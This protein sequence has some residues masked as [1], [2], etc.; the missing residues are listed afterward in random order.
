MK[1]FF[2]KNDERRA[3]FLSRVFGIFSEEIV[4][5]WI[6]D[7]RAP[8]RCGGGRPKLQHG[9]KKR[10]IDFTLQE[11]STNRIFVAEM[12]CE[13]AY[14]NFKF[15]TLTNPQQLDH[16][17][18]DA[19]NAFLDYAGKPNVAVIQKVPVKTHGAILIWGNT[20]QVGIDAVMAEYR[21]HDV[22]AISNILSDLRE[23]QTPAWTKLL[24][25]VQTW[26]NDLGEWLEFGRPPL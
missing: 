2:D 1:D 13:I 23:W 15:L 20:S 11:R 12:K 26:N 14:K 9:D 7:E 5:V 10:I 24:R 16:H 18:K 17:K 4:R 21:F 25:E 3:N 8:Y 22:L 19:F 6:D